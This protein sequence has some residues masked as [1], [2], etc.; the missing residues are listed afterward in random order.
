MTNNNENT[1]PRF[2][3]IIPTYQREKLVVSLIKSLVRQTYVEPIEVIVVVDGSTDNTVCALRNLAVPFPLKIVEQNNKGRA[4]ACNAGAEIA[5][6]E[7]FLFIDD[8]MEADPRLLAEHD[9]SHRTA[10][11]VFGHMPLN[12][13]S[14]PSL[15]TTGVMNWAEE[16][17][18]R[19]SAPDAILSIHDLLTG[20][21]SL[22]GKIFRAL[23]GF[24]TRF[25]E[26][27]SFGNEDIDFGFRLI[28]NKYRMVFNPRA[29][30]WQRYEVDPRTYLRRARETGRADVLFARKHP[31]QRRTIFQLISEGKWINRWFW[32]HAVNLPY[33]A[34]PLTKL[35]NWLT[36]RLV[37]QGKRGAVTSKLFSWSGAIQYWRGVKDAGGIPRERMLRILS[38]HAISDLSG[39]TVMEPYG[40]PP[41]QFRRQLDA[42][43]KAGFRFIS[44]DEFSSYLKGKAGI[45][46]RALLLTFD[47]C[48]RDLLENG[49]PILE[50]KKISA[51]TFAVSNCLGGTNTW[52][53]EI[54]APQLQLLD[55]QEL[56]QL[57]RRSVEVGAHSRTHP[58]LT[59][60]PDEQLIEEIEGSL[61]DLEAAGLRRPRFF[62]YP[63]GSYDQRVLEN[64]ESSGI[65]A[66]FTV[67]P[68]GFCPD[69]DH[70][71]VPRIEIMRND[72]GWR[73]LWKIW[74]A[75]RL[76]F[77]EYI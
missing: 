71:Q 52:D 43:E 9:C 17:V 54:G 20:Q 44:P 57:S 16:R 5:A 3:I 48:Y 67:K 33:L 12:P 77:W 63:H 68:R 70:L 29:I 49:L 22:P 45:P 51:V 2:S 65:I 27:G 24:D 66:A 32:R 23:G 37:D 15:L 36:L 39:M 72:V 59:K 38:Y 34:M 7:F 53:K 13:D 19:L 42:L 74:V 35:T 62:A 50:E 76:R 40:V 47:D 58:D 55:A 75:P 41:D 61:D 14:T 1:N 26:S 64:A 60:V 8:D 73:L 31:D 46:S 4:T 18:N 25:T 21:M 30:S 6:G 10:D 28:Q 56:E 11:V 69:K